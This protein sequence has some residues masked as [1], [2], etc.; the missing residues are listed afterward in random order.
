MQSRLGDYGDG[1]SDE[2]F[3]DLENY[4]DTS[5]LTHDFHPYPAKFIPQIPKEILHRLSEEGDW[6]LDPFCGSGTTLVESKLHNR[7]AIGIDVNPISCL[8]SRT[9]TT[10]L[11]HEKRNKAEER[12]S[13]IREDIFSGESYDIPDY[14]NIDYWFED[15]VM[16]ELSV[17]KHHSLK[18]DDSE[19]R[20]FL[21]TAMSA[22]LVKVSNQE[23]DTR[24]KSVDKDLEP[25]DV[26]RSF[27]DQAKE[28]LQTY[29][30]F[31][32]SASKSTV[33]IF[34]EDIQEFNPPDQ[35][36]DLVITSPPYPNS[37][38][39]YLYHKHRMYWLDFD[40][41]DVQERELGSRNKHSDHDMGLDKYVS[42]MN[43]A[44]RKTSKM[45]RDGH[46]FVVVIGDAII[47]DKLIKMDEV[48]DDIFINHGYDI[49]QK[50]RFDQRKY[51]RSFTPNYRTKDKESYL[52]VYRN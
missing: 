45:L 5:Y 40:P 44:V 35:E 50:L 18:S 28:M 13:D 49:D 42:P 37:Y 47:D 48:M 41:K 1:D 31:E 14:H 16:E 3:L 7:N 30:A 38:D 4:T 27:Y 34:K 43:T 22:I 51:T 6:V 21:F 19:I 25:R 9:K 39:Y 2:I 46:P 11:N 10:P 52:L 26:W 23:S 32:E 20:D 12:I 33:Q 36:I 8:I 15:F 17:I 29:R 24:Y